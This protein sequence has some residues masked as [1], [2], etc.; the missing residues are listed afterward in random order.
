MVE[1]LINASDENYPTP[2]LLPEEIDQAL[3]KN[4]ANNRLQLLAQYKLLEKDIL[5]EI[6]LA[7]R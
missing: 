2:Y 6:Y 4:P 7:A 3:E 1:Y 5:R